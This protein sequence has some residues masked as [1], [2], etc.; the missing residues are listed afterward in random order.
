MRTEQ[1]ERQMDYGTIMTLVREMFATE[2]ISRQE[3]SKIEAMYAKL[4]QPIYR[5]IGVPEPR[6]VS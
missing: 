3:F 6:Q 5:V 4:Y 1:F 2:L